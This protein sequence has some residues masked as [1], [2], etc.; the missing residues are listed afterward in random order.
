MFNTQQIQSQS[1]FI[2]PY[3]K[4]SY[5]TLSLALK[6]EREI[7]EAQGQNELMRGEG[8]DD[9]LRMNLRNREIGRK[10][11][12][13]VLKQ[14]RADENFER[15]LRVY[16]SDLNDYEQ[17][18]DEGSEK[19]RAYMKLLRTINRIIKMKGVSPQYID[20]AKELK[21]RLFLLRNDER[22]TQEYQR[23]INS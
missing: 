3:H 4:P 21:E 9:E 13:G 10:K 23:R 7:G 5:P 19:V 12:M 20:E 8:V 17:N 15:A 11:N 18:L 6:A 2:L 22:F 1:D 16:K 14:L